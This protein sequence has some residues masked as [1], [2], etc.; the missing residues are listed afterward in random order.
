MACCVFGALAIP[1]RS[2]AATPVL[3]AIGAFIMQFFVQGAWGVIPAH[4][5]QWEAAYAV[6]NFPLPPPAGAGYGRAMQVIMLGVFAA[7]FILTAIG[8][9]RRGVSFTDPSG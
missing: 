3:L 6:K 4:A 1:L 7:V 5:A 2:G 9:E 8:R